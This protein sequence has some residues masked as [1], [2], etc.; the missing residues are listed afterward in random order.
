MPY[1]IL[2]VCFKCEVYYHLFHTMLEKPR[3]DISNAL[4]LDMKYFVGIQCT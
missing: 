4:G 3:K 2:S 1:G